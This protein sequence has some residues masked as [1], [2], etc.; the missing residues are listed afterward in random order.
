MTKEIQE[1]IDAANEVARKLMPTASK[2]QYLKLSGYNA[3]HE[4]FTDR[5]DSNFFKTTGDTWSIEVDNV[6][7]CTQYLNEYSCKLSATP[8]DIKKATELLLD[9]STAI[10]EQTEILKAKM[11]QDKQERIKALKEEI[12]KLES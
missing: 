9:V 8:E 2:G 7:K 5:V 4:D 11:L 1:F 6:C 3:I 12:K 10:D